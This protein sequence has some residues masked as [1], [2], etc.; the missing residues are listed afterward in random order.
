[1]PAARRPAGPPTRAGRRRRAGPGRR[2]GQPGR[3]GVPWSAPSSPV[4]VL[5]CVTANLPSVPAEMTFRNRELTA[6]CGD[7]YRCGLPGCGQGIDADKAEELRGVGDGD[8]DGDLLA[9][10]GDGDGTGDAGVG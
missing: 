3:C 5:R 10:L 9:V 1:A 8:R 7:Q 2:D 4:S 6:L